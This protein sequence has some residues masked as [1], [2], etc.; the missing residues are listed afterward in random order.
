MMPAQRSR[1]RDA[2]LP[3]DVVAEL[4]RMMYG[5]RV[6]IR[7]M[8]AI[9]LPP[10]IH[11]AWIT[12]STWSRWSA[13]VFW[14]ACVFRIAVSETYA[15]RGSVA[16]DRHAQLAWQR[17]Y[18]ASGISCVSAFAVF[19]AS[20]VSGV[21]ETWIV[22]WVVAAS[23]GFGHGPAPY[24]SL[25]PPLGLVQV[26][27]PF[28]GPMVPLALSGRSGGLWLALFLLSGIVS[29][30]GHCKVEY[31]RTVTALLARNRS[32]RLATTDALT[33]LW[34]RRQL[35]AIVR[36]ALTEALPRLHWLGIDLDGFKGV[37]DGFGHEAG[38]VVLQAVARRIE[39]VAGAD[40]FVARV[41]GD[42]FVVLLIGDRTEASL[43]SERLTASLAEPIVVPEGVARIGASIGATAICPH[44][45]IDGIARRADERMYVRKAEARLAA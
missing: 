39:H 16:Q 36:Q 17:A 38:D 5:S 23:V 30:L 25:R 1:I 32:D 9:V 35:E 34:N 4:V 13:A 27:I 24:V 43:I 21:Y 37:N 33:G 22:V 15:V 31:E 40:A 26:T 3:D 6:G 2:D 29:V 7:L 10:T 42:E 19:A 18:F 12:D 8:M 41:G 28:L 11:V 44:D 20:I 45:T 14:V